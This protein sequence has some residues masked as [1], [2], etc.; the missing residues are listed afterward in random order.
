VFRGQLREGGFTVFADDLTGNYLAS[1]DGTIIDCNA[2]F[3]SIFGFRT[4]REARATNMATLWAEAR[5]HTE[6][7]AQIRAHRTLDPHECL[8]RRRDG[9]IIHLIE[10]AVGDFEHG[11]ELRR[12]HGRLFDKTTSQLAEHARREAEESYCQLLRSSPDAAVV[13]DAQDRIVFLNPAAARLLGAEPPDALLGHS[14]LQFYT[15]RDQPAEDA[16]P[17]APLHH[18]LV[19]KDGAVVDV[20]TMQTAIQFDGALCTLHI[21]RDVGPRLRVEQA[22]REKDR[23]VAVHLTKIEKLN[24]AL[25]TLMEH[26]EQESQRLLAGVRTTIEQ[27]VLAYLAQLKATPLG[28]DQRM[29]VEIT[30]ANLRDIASSFARDLESWEMKLTPTELQVADLLRQGKHTKEIA[31][32]LRVSHRAVTFHRNNLRAKLGLIRRPINLVSYLRTMAQPVRP[33]SSIGPRRAQRAAFG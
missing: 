15:P 17:D 4:R 12:I 6:F 7:V 20:E 13:S 27:L 33:G 21:S 14:L 1:P 23:E 5:A 9:L 25:T 28:P 31:R 2:T 19:R 30:E 32:L 16:Q 18:K 8:R 11:G 24:D 26:R 3:L 22:L 10:S 29:L